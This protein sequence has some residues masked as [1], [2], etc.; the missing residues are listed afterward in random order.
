L[1]VPLQIWKVVWLAQALLWR[2]G[3][4]PG[5]FTKTDEPRV[6]GTLTAKVQVSAGVGVSF[7]Q[8]NATALH[9][10]PPRGSAATT[11]PGPIHYHPGIAINAYIAELN[12]SRESEM[13]VFLV[14]CTW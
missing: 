10:E 13:F 4:L 6:F 2:S 5:V 12:N 3:R 11:P 1:A 8:L 7:F 14:L 9:P